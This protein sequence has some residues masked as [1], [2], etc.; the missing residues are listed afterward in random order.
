MFCFKIGD[1]KQLRAFM[2]VYTDLA[3]FNLCF[4]EFMLHPQ[5]GELN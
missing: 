4:R 5:K 3:A 1:E 2:E